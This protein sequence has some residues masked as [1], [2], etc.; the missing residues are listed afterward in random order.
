MQNFDLAVLA[1]TSVRWFC[2][3]CKGCVPSELVYQSSRRK[4]SCPP[5]DCPSLF[6]PTY[7]N[8]QCFLLFDL[9]WFSC[10]FYSC[11]LSLDMDI[12]MERFPLMLIIPFSPLDPKV[13]DQSRSWLWG[14]S[15]T[16]TV[17]SPHFQTHVETPWVW[18]VAV[19][20]CSELPEHVAWSQSV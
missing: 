2:S 12:G 18:P 20:I 7:L 3:I 4:L 8:F 19:R 9:M 5:W 16:A 11:L 15:F 17:Y 13:K 14:V 6:F 1:G 10:T